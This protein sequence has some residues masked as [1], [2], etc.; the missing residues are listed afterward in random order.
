MAKIAIS[1]IAGIFILISQ[2]AFILHELEHRQFV[3]S[4]FNLESTYVTNWNVGVFGRSD[5][6]LEL[7]LH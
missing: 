4:D 6:V 2:F 7:G 5:R 3:Q 1:L